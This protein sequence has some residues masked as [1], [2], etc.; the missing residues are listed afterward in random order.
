MSTFDSEI[1]MAADLGLRIDVMPDV[2]RAIEAA[3]GSNGL[4][5]TEADLGAGFFD[6]RSGLMGEL[7]QRFT[8][9]EI[10]LALVVSD[11]SVYG[12]RVGELAFEHRHHR[13]IRFFGSLE[14]ARAWLQTASP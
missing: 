3:Y 6:L 12:N 2:T 5:L 4:L 10:S 1:V 9:H 14:S 11:P 7:F 13:L 8:N